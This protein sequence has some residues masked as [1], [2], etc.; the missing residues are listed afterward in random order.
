RR[1]VVPPRLKALWCLSP[2]QAEALAR[3][4]SC[5][6]AWCGAK[7]RAQRLARVLLDL[8]P[9]GDPPTPARS[10]ADWT[11]RPEARALRVAEINRIEGLHP[12]LAA[13]PH[14]AASDYI[15]G[16]TPGS[17][18][19]GVRHEDLTHLTYPDD[20]FDLVLTS[21]TLEHVPDLDAALREIRRVLATG[22]RHLCT[23]PLLPGIPRTFA[24]TVVR[25][26]GT[27]DHLAPPIRHPGGDVG[28]PV[29]T[30]FGADWPEILR[31]AGFEVAVAFGPTT[32]DDLAQVTISRKMGS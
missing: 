5:D 7:L 28:Y 15:P 25:P 21:E 1:R 6:C 8:Y 19:D 13:L 30:E 9:V 3:K 23:V 14:F 20:A 11:R 24:R 16:A 22:G 26:D 18:V 12:V 27:L 2:R 32:D 17:V 31:R 4:E 29:F 10:V